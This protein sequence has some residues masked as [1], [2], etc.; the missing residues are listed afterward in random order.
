M[1]TLTL[2]NKPPLHQI[3]STQAFSALLS[4][5][6]F[7]QETI[8]PI[9]ENRR[10][11]RM[12]QKIDQALDH[13][14]QQEDSATDYIGHFMTRLWM[15]RRS[16][17]NLNLWL[18]IES[19]L[20]HCRLESFRELTGK[21]PSLRLLQDLWVPGILLPSFPWTKVPDS[22]GQKRVQ[23]RLGQIYLPELG[24][25]DAWPE[26]DPLQTLLELYRGWLRTM[27][28]RLTRT[29][30]PSLELFLEQHP[31]PPFQQ[32]Q[33]KGGI[34]GSL[35][36][37]SQP[38]RA[39]PCI[40][41][42]LAHCRRHRHLGYQGRLQLGG[43]LGAAR[44]DLD[45]TELVSSRDEQKHLVRLMRETAEGKF[46]VPSCRTIRGWRPAAR[47][48]DCHGCPMANARDCFK[49]LEDIMR[50]ERLWPSPVHWTKARDVFLEK[51][52]K[53]KT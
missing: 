51:K 26:S 25:N 29:H 6:K 13:L 4:R 12:E 44:P 14:K 20:L 28:L 32:Q 45:P 2:Y 9:L 1:Q 24:D 53:Q 38:V 30:D 41:R 50:Q 43:W 18:R 19:F 3:H 17:T 21:Y 15:A 27:T 35:V 31:D 23:L 37:L 47:T 52:K 7:L 10:F 16:P 34:K 40:N 49:D 22:V 33:S 36:D 42:L 11:S 8:L 46:M 39:P 5:T 48:Q